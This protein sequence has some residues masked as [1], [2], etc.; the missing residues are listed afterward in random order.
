MSC[1]S[2]FLLRPLLAGM[3]MKH[4][5]IVALL[6]LI[7]GC[8][9]IESD[10]IEIIQTFTYTSVGAHG[11]TGQAVS[12]QMRMAQS[13]DSLINH[14]DSCYI[15][16]VWSAPAPLLHD[17]VHLPLTVDMDVTYYFALKTVNNLPK[18]SG[19]SNIINLE[20][21]DYSPP[22]PIGDFDAVN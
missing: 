7:V 5:L 11:L 22:A 21:I 8:T 19:I 3:D 13:E 20:W 12:V 17:T 18:W 15:V 10:P 4:L 6:A 14:W 2:S 1:C 9:A 16:S